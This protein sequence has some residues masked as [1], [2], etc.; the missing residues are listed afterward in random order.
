MVDRFRS[1]HALEILCTNFLI[2]HKLFRDF[3]NLIKK[4]S[5]PRYLFGLEVSI[6]LQSKA[7][8]MAVLKLKL[9]CNRRGS[10]YGIGFR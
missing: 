6:V 8:Y 10:L 1:K 5:I 4:T 7:E 3:F 2:F 9:Y